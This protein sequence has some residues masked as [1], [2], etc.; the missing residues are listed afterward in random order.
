MFCRIAL[1]CLLA[2]T[3][4]AAQQEQPERPKVPKDSLLVTVAGCIKGR[5]IRAADVRQEDTTSGYTIRSTSF[6]IEGKKDVMKGVKEQD[7]QRAEIIGLIKKSSLIEPGIKFK[8]GRV[9]VGGGTRSG[10]SSMPSPAENVLVLDA[11]S[12]QGLGGSCGS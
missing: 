1:V 5:V 8:G 11:M 10:P 3:P 7:G 2:A 4:L 6:R 12:I 9:I